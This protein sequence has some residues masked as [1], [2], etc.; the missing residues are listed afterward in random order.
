MAAP[1]PVVELVERFDRQRDAYRSGD[2]NEAR[3][4]REFIDPLFGALGWDMDNRRGYAEAY[5]DVIH[6]DSIKVGTGTKAPDY[7]FRIGTARKFFVEAKKPAVNI[8]DDVSP[9]YQLRRYAWSAKLPLSILTDFEEFAIY[10]CRVRPQV[11]D[12]ASAARLTYLTFEDYADKWDEI[13]A[14]FSREAVL[15]GAFDKFADTSKGK[16]G[17]TEVDDAFLEE[18]EQ[19]RESLAGNIALR[20]PRISQSDLGFAVQR[21]IDRIIFLRICE[22]R[23]IE[24]YG[25]LQSLAKTPNLYRKLLE[26]FHRADERYNSGL[27]HFR[28][29]SDRTEAPDQLTPELVLDDKPLRSILESL[30]YPASPY[31]FSIL[32]ADILGHVYERFL[33]KVIR[34]TAAHRVKI[35]E[36]PEV[37]KAGG[38]YYT[39]NYIVGYIVQR[40]LGKLLEGKSPTDAMQVRVLDPACGSGSF[41][42]GAYQYLLDWH[43]QWCLDHDPEKL[44]GQKQPPLFRGS[45]GE[46]RLTARKRKEILV[47][48]IFGVDLDAQAIEVTKLSLL[49]K[50]LE[51]ETEESINVALKLF[52]DRALPDLGKN[53]RHGNSLVGPDLLKTPQLRLSLGDDDPYVPFDWM[54][55]FPRVFREGGFDVV[56]GNP[57]Y[58]SFAGRQSVEIPDWLRKFYTEAYESGGW[59]TAHTLFLERAIKLL[60]RRFAS[61]I[62]PDQVGHLAGYHSIRDIALR[63][64]GLVEVRYWGEHVF[65]G[66]ITPA[67]TLVL[68]K[69]NA[70]CKTTVFDKEGDERSGSIV[71]GGTWN[72]SPSI[73]LIQ[74]LR[75]RS[76]S[77]GKLV[78]DCGIRTTAAK[79]QVFSLDSVKGRFVPTLEGK[80]IQRYA[81]APPEVAVRTDSKKSL[82]LGNEERRRQA[83]FVIRQTAAFPI[84]GPREHAV[85]FRNS[86]LALFAP[87]E[88]GVDI[89]YIVALL[90]S[91]VLRFVYTETV[92]ESQQRTFPQVKVGALQTLPIREIDFSN[93]S[94]R[95]VH[96][97]LVQLVTDALEVQRRT[98]KEKNPVRK[99]AL[100]RNF[101]LL[102]ERIESA[103]FQLY[104]LSAEEVATVYASVGSILDEAVVSEKAVSWR[105]AG[106][107]PVGGPKRAKREVELPK[108]KKRA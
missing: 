19:W 54:K 33:G 31:E 39:P 102:D 8:K 42:L 50:V 86:L 84:V 53:I 11:Q 49:L 2:Y 98:A 52:H 12:K 107:N 37:R 28:R 60:S 88:G 105:P 59:P 23:G 27:F 48:N 81:C 29:E 21:T 65:R 101:Q 16:R 38:V 7:C 40:T 83:Q 47:A 68:D 97:E 64:A 10:D 15:R 36:K 4:R 93:V 41:L 63:Q 46:W 45:R 85:N 71:Q 25:H 76:F 30:Y 82:Y 44:A 91:K 13:E 6:E 70:N 74:R 100:M 66:A 14:T 80:Q 43:L 34:L 58:L 78:G 108:A 89:R 17:T 79:E 57:P 87:P 90:N 56:I 51:G 26:R 94:E 9:A 92:R 22:D 67:L 106:A 96:D 1:G 95:R 72:F 99:E 77:L 5:K 3:L 73:A 103:V 18:I 24:S 55:S 32:S 35:E 20:N 61:F 104:D 62:V 69:E 75:E